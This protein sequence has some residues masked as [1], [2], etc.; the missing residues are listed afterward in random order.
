MVVTIFIRRRSSNGAGDA[1]TK[2]QYRW[3]KTLERFA[4]Y[5][6]GFRQTFAVLHLKILRCKDC[7]A[8]CQEPIENAKPR[9]SYSKRFARYVLELASITTLSTVSGRLG[10][11]WD[12]GKEIVKEDLKRKA[13]RR[14]YKHIRVIAIDEISAKK[15]HNYLTLITDLESGHVIFVAEGKDSECLNPFFTKLRRARAKLKACAIDMSGAY[16]KAI[17][18]TTTHRFPTPKPN[19]S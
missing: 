16:E 12:L 11:G 1:R 14:K 13:K 8:E 10:I 15:G 6:F 4:S 2:T 9:K 19:A 3:E 7:K 5:L 17:N 18:N